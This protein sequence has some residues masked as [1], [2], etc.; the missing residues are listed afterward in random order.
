MMARMGNDLTGASDNLRG[1]QDAGGRKTATE[2]RTSFEAGGSRLAS[3]AM[4]YSGMAVVPSA[5]QWASNFQQFLSEEMEMRVLGMD[6]QQHS[7]RITPEGIEGDFFFP[8]NDGTLPLDKVASLDVWRQIW[9]AVSQDPSGRMQQEY[10][11]PAIFRFMAKLGGAQNIDE[12]RV[13]AAGPGAIDRGAQ[14][15]NL[16]P[17]SQLPG[18]MAQLGGPPPG[19]PQLPMMEAA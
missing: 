4:L 5:E 11:G 10:N 2:V 17:L 12:F 1:I 6:G 8:I 14:S 18:A 19:G 16:V 9:Q 3:R 7:I 13:T 15:G